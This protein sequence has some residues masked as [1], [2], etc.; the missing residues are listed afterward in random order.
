MSRRLVYGDLIVVPA[1]SLID[2]QH[3]ELPSHL[4]LLRPAR[5]LHSDSNSNH[6]VVQPLR[7]DEEAP[8]AIPVGD[9]MPLAI[10][11]KHVRLDVPSPNM[12]RMIGY[13][14]NEAVQDSPASLFCQAWII[15]STLVSST[16]GIMGL[17]PQLDPTS[18]ALALQVTA[19]D[20]RRP[21]LPLIRRFTTKG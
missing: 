17:S 8:E 21:D 10:L 1:P 11:Y 4:R 9:C 18:E 6:H 15:A 7:P 2:L 5:Y 14:R 12:Q 3:L 20:D 19:S 16:Y 13:V